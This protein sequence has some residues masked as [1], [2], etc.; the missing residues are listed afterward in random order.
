MFSLLGYFISPVYY[1][2]LLILVIYLSKLLFSIIYSI[3]DNK[4]KL[5]A[6][7]YLILVVIN[8]FSFYLASNFNNDFSE[9][10]SDGTKSYCNSYFFCFMN[11][12]NLGL[13]KGGGL[14][15]AMSYNTL[16]GDPN[17]YKRLIFDLLFFILVTLV[18]LGI[19]LGIIVDA[20]GDLRDDINKWNYDLRNIC[21][22]CGLSKVEL[23]KKGIKFQ[24]H[25]K[26]HHIMNYLYYI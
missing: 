17:F 6:A 15:D 7:F 12:L 18:L 19:F 26:F 10:S 2:L 23:E 21:F 3:I 20:F 11:S 22:T 8:T 16:S 4:G 14:S 25:L 24:K 5:I 13:W 1:S 9:Q